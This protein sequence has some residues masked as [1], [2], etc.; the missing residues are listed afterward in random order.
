M[1]TYNI[2]YQ[3]ITIVSEV[4][5]EELEKTLIQV[6]GLVILTGKDT[7]EIKVILNKE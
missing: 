5:P 1:N 4:P 6:K 3:G 2:K 7:E